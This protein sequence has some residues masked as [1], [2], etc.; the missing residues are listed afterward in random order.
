MS[1]DTCEEQLY[2]CIV[3]IPVLPC[4]SI[5]TYVCSLLKVHV[6]LFQQE[7]HTWYVSESKSYMNSGASNKKWDLGHTHNYI[8]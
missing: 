5:Y 4:A 7:I 8:D 2:M 6:L 3:T 1:G